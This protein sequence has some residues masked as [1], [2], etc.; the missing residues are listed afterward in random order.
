LVDIGGDHPDVEVGLIR[1]ESQVIEETRKCPED[2]LLR[3]PHCCGVVD[4]EQDIEVVAAEVL[5][6]ASVGG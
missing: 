3:F 1:R 4:D 5:A 6:R 2:S